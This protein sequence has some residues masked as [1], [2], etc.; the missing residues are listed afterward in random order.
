MPAEPISGLIGLS[1][2]RFIIFA[3]TTPEAVPKRNAKSPSTT[4]ATVWNVRN[5]SAAMVDPMA[6]VK[7]IMMTFMR[8]PAAVLASR[9]VTPDSFSRL[10][11]INMVISGNRRK[12]QI[13]NDGDH[14]WKGDFFQFSHLSEL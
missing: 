6:T 14:E 11:S 2:K 8:P 5:L 12:K 4:I 3:V 10:P 1:K 13:D 9:S 7:T